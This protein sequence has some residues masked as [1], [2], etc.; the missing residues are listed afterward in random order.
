VIQSF[1]KDDGSKLSEEAL[2]KYL[3]S[4]FKSHQK[5]DDSLDVRQL[6]KIG[7]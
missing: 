5:A 1:T 6:M 2:K 7:S 3:N 4:N